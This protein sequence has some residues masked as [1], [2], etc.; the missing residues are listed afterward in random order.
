MRFSVQKPEVARH[1]LSQRVT[2][3]DLPSQNHTLLLRT[4]SSYAIHFAQVT[5]QLQNN[6]N[7]SMVF[8]SRDVS[9]DTTTPTTPKSPHKINLS[10]GKLS[11]DSLNIILRDEG[12]LKDIEMKGFSGIWSNHLTRLYLLMFLLIKGQ[13]NLFVSLTFNE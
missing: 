5:M 3:A 8:G 9:G 4:K 1:S 12:F 11:L 2:S 7:K 10:A 13:E 6:L